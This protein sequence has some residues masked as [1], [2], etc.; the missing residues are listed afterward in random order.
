MTR[1][2]AA[3]WIMIFLDAARF[4]DD[5]VASI[6]AQ[7]G[8]PVWELL[9]VDDGSTDGS[10]DLARAWV[11][12]FPTRIRY[13]CHPGH[14]NRGMSASRNLGLQQA[15]GDVIGFLD[16]DDILLPT[17]MARALDVLAAHPNADAVIGRTQIWFGWTGR[18]RDRRRDHLLD[19]P[20]AV[21][22]GV[23]VE[24]P[25]WF[26]GMYGD[27]RAWMVPAVCGV[28]VRRAALVA[29]GGSQTDFR[30]M[31]EDQVMY[32]KIGLGCHVVLD[33][34]LYA[35]YRQHRWSACSVDGR[36]D[37]WNPWR[38]N[39]PQQIFLAWLAAHVV[40][41][42]GPGTAEAAAVARLVDHRETLSSGVR[43]LA[44]TMRRGAVDAL[45]SAVVQ[46]CRS[47]RP[48]IP[49]TDRARSHMNQIEQFVRRRVP[50]PLRRLVRRKRGIDGPPI[51]LARLGDLRR[52]TPIADDFGYERGG[53]V[54][55]YYIEAFLE[56]HR[57]DVRGRCLEIGDAEY[58]MRFGGSA[59]TRPDVLHVDANAPGATFIGDLA[60]G[61][62]LPSDTFDC[63]VLTQTLHLIYDF[64]AALTTL[65][66]IL[67]PGGVLLLTVPGI[68]NVD[69]AEWG[70]TWHYGFT[71]HSVGRM[72]ADA[73]PDWSVSTRSYGNVLA[74]V[75]FLHGLSAVELTRVELD[76]HRVEY[77]LIHAVRASKP[78]T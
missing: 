63:I 73:F 9:L 34:T 35:R 31:Y 30:G 52:T 11:A 56:E 41:S 28:V 42:R 46:R 14:A 37:H 72:C 71:H 27:P 33:D 20:P 26:L 22:P 10:T 19:H 51:G 53:P 76:D 57:S 6:V 18:E 24:P 39:P 1:D 32:A 12:R 69:P 13:L 58:T 77:S 54:D 16:S 75:A 8:A 17:A 2:P 62:F 36:T 59:V 65:G 74:A 78:G 50:A 3:S 64:R 47:P 23:A 43:R 68:S 40:A 44:W 4:I 7:E 38:S 5:A 55:R 48:D 66:R 45:P 60:E 15:R 49:H 70:P 67:T 25:Q 21:P 61:D 29:L